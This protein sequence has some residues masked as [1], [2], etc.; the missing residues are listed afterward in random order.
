VKALIR[1]R[2]A[3]QSDG[4]KGGVEDVQRLVSQEARVVT[5]CFRTTNSDAHAMESD[6]PPAVA[7]LENRQ[8]RVGSRLLSLSQSNQAKGVEGAASAIA[9]RVKWNTWVLR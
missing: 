9:M 4:A 3:H 5:G 8:R 2:R 1:L 7:L 6:L